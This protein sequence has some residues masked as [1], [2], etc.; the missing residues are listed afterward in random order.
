MYEKLKIDIQ[1]KT[2]QQIV[3]RFTDGSSV[4]LPEQPT[5]KLW[6]ILRNGMAYQD[7]EEFFKEADTPALSMP[8][9]HLLDMAR[10]DSA[11]RSYRLA[12]AE[13]LY[14]FKHPF[15]DHP[16][17]QELIGVIKKN[18]LSKT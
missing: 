2:A 12:A 5:S 11:Q 18:R 10:N 17:L 1:Y 9:Q 4:I 8:P 6:G 15:A 14:D 16:D 7:F 13:I 3:V